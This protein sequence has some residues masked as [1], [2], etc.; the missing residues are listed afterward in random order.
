MKIHLHS[1][2]IGFRCLALFAAI[3]LFNLATQAGEAVILSDT[4]L[5]YNL[6]PHVYVS[7]G[8]DKPIAFDKVVQSEA[9]M[10]YERNGRESV[11]LGHTTKG[12]WLKFKI[13][14]STSGQYK[15]LLKVKNALI[16]EIALY[17]VFKDGRCEI[18]HAGDQVAYG[19]RTVGHR[20]P[21]FN[22]PIIR[23][24]EQVYYMYVK[25][26]GGNLNL[27]IFVWQ[28]QAHG[29]EDYRAQYGLGIYY[30]IV[31][32]IFLLNLFLFASL[33]WR[34]YLLYVLYMS[35]LIVFQL[36]VDGL[37][38]QYLWSD[39]FWWANHVIPL[40][41]PLAMIF[42][43]Q[44]SQAFL[45]TKKYHHKIH[46]LFNGLSVA[47]LAVLL[48]SLFGNP[49]YTYALVI[50]K[51]LVLLVNLSIIGA[52][53]IA[54]Q[55][56]YTAYAIFLLGFSTLILGVTVYVLHHDFNLF[57]EFRLAQYAIHIGSASEFVI[58]TLALVFRFKRTRDASIAAQAEAYKLL[59]D[60]NRL[61]DKV[62]RELEQK[63]NERTEEIHEKNRLLREKN[64]D[65]TDS[66]RYAK[67][68]QKAIMPPIILVEERLQDHF[69]YFKPRDIV[70]GDF[71]WVDQV[72]EDVLLA[73]ADCTGHGVPGAFMSIVGHNQLNHIVAQGRLSQP[74]QI[75][76]E[77]NV[78]IHN[79][80][81][82]TDGESLVRDG[83]DISVLNLNFRSRVIQFAAA[84]NPLYIVRPNI[85]GS[86]LAEMTSATVFGSDL[87]E[88]KANR[89]SVGG[90]EGE[91]IAEFTNHSIQLE[92]GDC[93]YLFSDGIV[94]Q[95]GGSR[96][97]K[98][99][100]KRLKELLISL[101]PLSMKDQ[102]EAIANSFLSWMGGEDQIDDVCII[103]IRI[104]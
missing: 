65:I 22:I 74:N 72:G 64:R 18:Q 52:T 97:R 62:N 103:G 48:L 17:T 24:N 54:L 39:H 63:V 93:I 49:L 94:D 55:R 32:L 2:S 21:V 14:N 71:Y 38:F 7:R 45:G 77:L 29:F 34:P 35:A 99:K 15:F 61:K 44:F 47:A 31:L 12:Y 56:N 10:D 53:I 41:G 30:G 100:H 50:I 11:F 70:S 60:K 9:L 33:K 6:S 92:R 69:L 16:D 91:T 76:N 66:I 27:P 81:R 73:L 37:G 19:L 68:I 95:F 1:M 57:P 75:L 98:Y 43:L 42:A 83:M 79:T 87:V 8:F 46:K 67:H 5:S 36:A 89:C 40:S 80:L 20:Y 96:G 85:G 78:G 84:R 25:S 86:R 82:Q 51:Y 4:I 59:E 28:L 13:S 58:L 26:N 101:N 3:T 104:P 23:G 88:V 102:R 90:F